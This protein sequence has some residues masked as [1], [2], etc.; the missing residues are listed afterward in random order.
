MKV[1]RLL[2]ALIGFL[3]MLFSGG[4]TLVAVFDPTFQLTGPRA[5][6]DL[7]FLAIFG[8][9]PFATGFVI[10]WLAIRPRSD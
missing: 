5:S 4:C 3:I 1:I 6:E 9:L 10:W 8:L 7:M 2:F